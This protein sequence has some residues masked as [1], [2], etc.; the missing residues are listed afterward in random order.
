[1]YLIAV[2]PISFEENSNLYKDLLN[3]SIYP[4]PNKG[5]LNINY[6]L[7]QKAI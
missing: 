5:V 6:N 4:N 1:M 2:S 3:L 7:A